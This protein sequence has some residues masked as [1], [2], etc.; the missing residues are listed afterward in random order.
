MPPARSLSFPMT[1]SSTV[2]VPGQST[3]SLGLSPCWRASAVVI[4]LNVDP[5][6]RAACY[7]ILGMVGE[8]AAMPKMAP[9]DGWIATIAEFG[10]FFSASSMADCTGIF[11]VV[12]SDAEVALGSVPSGQDCEFANW[13]PVLAS[14]NSMV[15][16]VGA[17]PA[18]IF[19]ASALTADASVG[20]AVLVSIALPSASVTVAFGGTA[21]SSA[22]ELSDGWMTEYFQCTAGAPPEGCT[23]S[24]ADW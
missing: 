18:G 12:F 7:A 14:V 19:V 16:D 4:T 5:G 15:S 11:S 1:L 22:V 17:C 3:G 21:F 24:S 23:S 10:Y 6:A 8:L 20:C 9:V 13:V 2:V